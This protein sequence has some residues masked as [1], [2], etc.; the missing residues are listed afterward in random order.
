MLIL[1]ALLLGVSLFNVYNYLIKQGK[2]KDATNNV[3]YFAITS[4]LLA[5][6]IGISQVS[7]TMDTCSLLLVIPMWWVRWLNFLVAIC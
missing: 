1:A 3:L 6:I 4:I 7:A 2:Y 5:L